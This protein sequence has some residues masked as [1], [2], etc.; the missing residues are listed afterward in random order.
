[1]SNEQEI[2]TTA[3][4]SSCGNQ[5][6]DHSGATYFCPTE[7]ATQGAQFRFTDAVFAS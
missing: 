7:P 1:M 3:I 5:R 2:P 4:C 6:G